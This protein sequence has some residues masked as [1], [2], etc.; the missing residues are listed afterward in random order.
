M[1]EQFNKKL[2]ENTPGAVEG[3]REWM[4]VIKLICEAN[5]YRSKI[6]NNYLGIV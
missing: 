3:V 6:Q 2:W 5:Y 4:I 1:K